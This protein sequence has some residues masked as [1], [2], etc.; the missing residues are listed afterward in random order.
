MPGLQ[1][2]ATHCLCAVSSVNSWPS[3]LEAAKA[4]MAASRPQQQEVDAFGKP[5]APAPA[6]PRR[7]LCKSEFLCVAGAQNYIHVRP[8]LRRRMTS[9]HHRGIGVGLAELHS[10]VASR[11]SAR[12]HRYLTLQRTGKR[13]SILRLRYLEQKIRTFSFAIRERPASTAWPAAIRRPALPDR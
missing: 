12:A 4:T 2:M 1:P 3:I 13:R 11:A 9:D 8:V 7:T 6:C 5:A 10:D